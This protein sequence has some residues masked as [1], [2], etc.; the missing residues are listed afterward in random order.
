MSRSNPTDNSP[1]PSVRWHEWDGSNGAVRYYDRNAPHP[2]KKGEKGANVQCKLPFTFIVLDDLSTIKGWHEASESSIYSNEVRDTR[3][4]TFVVKSYDGGVLAEGFYSAIRDRVFAL[5]GHFTTNLYIAFKDG[6][7][8]LQ[9]GSLQVKGAAL[10]HWVE[11]KK[12]HR[13][14]IMKKAVVITGFKDGKKGKIEFRTPVFE[15]KD[16]TEKTNAEALALDMLLQNYLKGYFKRT[17][18]EQVSGKPAMQEHPADEPQADA[19]P[20]IDHE[21]EP[22]GPPESDDVPF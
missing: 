10:N 21:P 8:V 2:T 14:D 3:Q 17:R 12:K 5:G 20:E 4:E 16:I 11:F 18:T 13:D 9:I 1:N 19:E 7:G 22:D 6:A 15:I